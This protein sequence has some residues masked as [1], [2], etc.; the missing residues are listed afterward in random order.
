[1]ADVRLVNGASPCEGTVEVYHDGEWGTIMDLSWDLDVAEVLCRQLGCGSAVS[2]PVGAHFGPGSG[3]VL[4]GGVSC[5]GSE[6][7]LRDCG[8]TEVKQYGFPH[9]FDAGVRCSGVRL[10]GGRSLCSGRVEVLRGTSWDT[11]CEADFDMK[12][13]EVVCRQLD[14]GF[15]AE[16]L[17]GAYFG[18]GQG[19]IRTEEIQCRGNE[20]R[21][22]D[23]PTSTR[24]HQSCAHSNDISLVCTEYSGYRLVDGPDS[25]SGR[26][27]LQYRGEYRTVCDQYWDLRDATVLCQQLGC[28]EAVAAPGQAWFG[29]GSGSRGVD[30][31]ECL[32]NET[33]LSHCAVS[34]WGR[35]ACSQGQDAGVICS[36]EPT[37]LLISAPCV[38]KH[39]NSSLSA[40]DGGVRLSG[41]E[42]HCDGR[43]EVHYNSTWGRLLQHSWGY[44]E[45]SVVC[46]Q[47][48][49]GSVVQ[50]YHSSVYE[51]G[52][53][54]VCLTGIQCSGDETH[55]V[56]CSSPQT[57]SCSAGQEVSLLCS[58]RSHLFNMNTCCTALVETDWSQ[59][60]WTQSNVFGIRSLFSENQSSHSNSLNIS[61]KEPLSFQNSVNK[62]T[63]IEH[64]CRLTKK[65]LTWSQNNFTTQ[66]KSRKKNCTGSS[67]VRLVNGASPCEGTVEIQYKG[68][69][70]TVFQANWDLDDAAVVCRQLGCG[71]AVSA[72]GGAH[73]GPGSGSV[74]LGDVSCRGSEA[75]LRDCGKTEVKHYPLPRDSD[76][77][78]RCSAH[79]GVR[80]VGGSDICSGRV[81]L[82]H[83]ETWGSV[84]DSDFGWQDAEVV[85]RELD[86]GV[87]SQVLKGAHFGKGEGQV[88]TEELQCQGNESQIFSC[89]KSSTTS[90]NCTHENNV[91]LVCFGYTGF[92]LVNGSDSCSGRVELQW[93]FK[94]WGTVC[95]LY[96][97]LTDASVLCQQLGCGEAVAAPGQAWFG[98]GSGPVWADVFECR[99]N[100][101]RLSHCTVSSWGRAGCSHGQDAGVICSV[102]FFFLMHFSVFSTYIT[103]NFSKGTTNT[104][105]VKHH[106]CAQ[107]SLRLVGAGSDCAGR[108]EVYHNG[109]W[110]TVCDDSWGLAD[111]QVVCKQ[112]QCGTALSA[113]VPASF[114]Q[115]TGTIWLNKVGCLGNESSLWE[116]PSAGWGQHDCGHKEDVGV[117]CS[118]FK[119]LRLAEGCSGQLEVFYN[120]T[121]GNVCWNSMS[122]DTVSLI[123]QELNCGKSGRVVESRPR[124]DSAPHWL[125]E[126]KCRPHDSTLWHCPSSAWNQNQCTDSEVALITCSVF[127]H[128]LCWTRN[129]IH[130]CSCAVSALFGLAPNRR[131]VAV[132]C[133]LQWL[134]WRPV[135]NTEMT[136]NR[137]SV[138]LKKRGLNVFEHVENDISKSKREMFVSAQKTV[139]G[140]DLHTWDCWHPPLGQSDC[141]HKEDA[142]V[143]CTGLLSVQ[144]YRYLC[145]SPSGSTRTTPQTQQ[146]GGL[147]I[148]LPVLLPLGA[149][150]F[151]VLALLVWQL[152]H[153][154][155]LRKALSKGAHTPYH[156]AVYEEISQ[157]ETLHQ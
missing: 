106:T 115:G 100:E 51:T 26:V 42:S 72:P 132:C 135:L 105:L 127:V 103:L 2:A 29:Q 126:F 111:S 40:L 116:C 153:N 131:G 113:P 140:Y 45:A 110:G 19:L 88:W 61:S 97:D 83:G 81:E 107:R 156:D 124:R 96:W 52:D 84:C 22:H 130:R 101:S 12:D 59:D 93:L 157:R 63:S 17:R 144:E 53:S 139:A 58:G 25:C 91:G 62:I 143:T 20:T 152:I 85:C 36:S 108:L 5:S 79:R 15:P 43:V 4:L 76:A 11:I 18:E 145:P 89:P 50:I 70:G 38:T 71:S 49:C 104:P 66:W 125:D 1:R 109:S 21:I 129:L 13:A 10:A 99:G 64:R 39:T 74:L 55:L 95:D 119:E 14:C 3:S 33:R 16:L 86:C 46:R 28:G 30:V 69:W 35:A 141:L 27:E 57:V 138:C 68:E 47:L 128:G 98:Q 37:L 77:G 90:Q 65:Q 73:F 147:S 9:D 8:K 31:F 34:S 137:P 24:E 136:A 151:V 120:G 142:G 118:E 148:S 48:G 134:T 6:S 78:V 82:Q 23:C 54:A 32:G 112:L 146:L 150:L 80:L 87:P 7:A 117:V 154:R 67:G 133:L 114:S 75:A 44:R 155:K 92:R 121:W 60:R 41:G 102:K 94:D 149:L 56:N 122:E 123:C